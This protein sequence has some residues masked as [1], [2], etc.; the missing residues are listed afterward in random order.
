[1][2]P[3]ETRGIEYSMSETDINKAMAELAIQDCVFHLVME[4]EDANGDI[5]TTER[6]IGGYK[7]SGEMAVLF[8]ARPEMLT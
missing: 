3:D 5:Q 7:L 6:K 8:Y 1:M 2:S 4:Y